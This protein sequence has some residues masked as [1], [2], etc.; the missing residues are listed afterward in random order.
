MTKLCIQYRPFPESASFCCSFFFLL[1]KTEPV[2]R[3][4]VFKM[5]I[6]RDT[7]E[8]TMTT[9]AHLSSLLLFTSPPQQ[10][11]NF[12]SNHLPKMDLSELVGV[13]KVTRGT[14]SP[15]LKKIRMYQPTPS[16]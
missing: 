11:L 14:E 7:N 5:S 2:F 16:E 12:R 4:A 3:K 6:V 10:P 9:N 1:L 13:P 8:I 15:N